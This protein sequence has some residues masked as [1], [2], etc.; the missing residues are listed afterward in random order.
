MCCEHRIYTLSLFISDLS[1]IYTLV[2]SK[3]PINKFWILNQQI[4]FA[5]MCYDKSN[6]WLLNKIL[7]IKQDNIHKGNVIFKKR[8]SVFCLKVSGKSERLLTNPFFF[9][10]VQ[11]QTQA[12]KMRPSRRPKQQQLRCVQ[13]RPRPRGT[14]WRTPQVNLHPNQPAP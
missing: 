13:T 2:N 3:N 9:L 11:K 8:K 14:L 7:R 10:S 4:T 5:K 12:T 6:F 1:L